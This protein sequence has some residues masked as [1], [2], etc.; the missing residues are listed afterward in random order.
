MKTPKFTP[1]RLN[2]QPAVMRGCS[3]PELYS[4]MIRSFLFSIPLALIFAVFIDNYSSILGSVPVFISIFFWGL[5]K[6]MA[7]LKNGRPIGYFT[8]RSNLR[9]QR[10]GMGKFYIEHDGHWKISKD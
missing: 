6:R 5:T 2:E 1:D 10:R 3:W 9:K 8:V 7:S 4:I